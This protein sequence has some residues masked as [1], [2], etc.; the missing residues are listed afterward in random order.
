MSWSV[1]GFQKCC[2][3]GL[4]PFN[5]HHHYWY[6]ISCIYS[7]QP[8]KLLLVLVQSVLCI[9]TM[10]N[11]D[12]YHICIYVRETSIYSYSDV[13]CDHFGKLGCRLQMKMFS[14]MLQKEVI[15]SKLQRFLKIWCLIIN[16]CYRLSCNISIDNNVG[17]W[18]IQVPFHPFI[19][20]KQNIWKK[21]L[22]WYWH[23]PAYSPSYL[24]RYHIQ[25]ECCT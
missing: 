11:L 22:Q 2:Y 23:L 12:K 3:I 18:K 15:K 24:L 17:L 8:S 13:N 14:R 4:L 7:L 16:E 5:C 10:C 19:S 21:I 25:R 9:I 6:F 20:C 1:C